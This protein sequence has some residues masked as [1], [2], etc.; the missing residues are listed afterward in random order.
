[1]G[2]N[3]KTEIQWENTC[4]TC[5]RLWVQ[6]LILELQSQMEKI[7]STEMRVKDEYIWD[8]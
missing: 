1:M 5:T 7:I 2:M 4:L 6:S 8:W 3:F